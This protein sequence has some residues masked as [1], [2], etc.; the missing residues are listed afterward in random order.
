MFP[1]CFLFGPN[2]SLVLCSQMLLIYV[3]SYFLKFELFAATV[4]PRLGRLGTYLRIPTL[5]LLFDGAIRRQNQ[6]IFLTSGICKLNY[7]ICNNTYVGQ[8]AS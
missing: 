7:H 1:T 3:H 8:S 2:I 4:V 6:K 5:N